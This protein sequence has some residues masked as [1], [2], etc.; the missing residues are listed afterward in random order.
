MI[1]YKFFALS[2]CTICYYLKVMV[3][4]IVMVLG[5]CTALAYIDILNIYLL[6]MVIFCRVA[7]KYAGKLYPFFD[8]IKNFIKLTH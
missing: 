5:F 4:V 8:Q 2:N 3:M 1:K 7:K 6:I